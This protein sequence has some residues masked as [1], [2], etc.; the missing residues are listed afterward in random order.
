MKNFI[1]KLNIGYYMGN[2]DL[3]HDDALEILCQNYDIS[4]DNPKLEKLFTIAWELGHASGHQSV[5]AY[6]EEMMDL[7]RFDL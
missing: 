1:H 2:D 7:I 4:R 3:F 5:W 6:M